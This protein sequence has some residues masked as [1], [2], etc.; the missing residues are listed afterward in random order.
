[1]AKFYGPIGFADKVETRP[2]V[3]EEKITERTYYGDEIKN[4]RRTQSS[5]EVND[6]I[7]ISNQISIL[8]D[9]FAKENF[10]KIRYVSYMGADWKIT[11][12]EPR[13]PRLI[14]TMGGLYNGKKA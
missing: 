12:V 7:D 14:L 2:G 6:N 11:S 5:N 8:A 10:Y 13:Y 9:P 1:M 4:V 3:W